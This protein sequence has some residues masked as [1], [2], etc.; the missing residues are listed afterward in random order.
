MSETASLLCVLP[1][2]KLVRKAVVNLQLNSQILQNI[3]QKNP[4]QKT[5]IEYFQK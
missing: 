1:A 5:G 2:K 4:R 3:K